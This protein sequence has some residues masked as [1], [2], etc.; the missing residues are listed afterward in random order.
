MDLSETYSRYGYYK[1]G[2]NV[3]ADEHFK[4]MSFQMFIES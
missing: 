3:L 4:C 1:T 2:K